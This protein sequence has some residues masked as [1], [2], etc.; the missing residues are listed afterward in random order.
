MKR[1]FLFLT[2]LML[3]NA[4]SAKLNVYAYAIDSIL[5][6]DTSIEVTD[7]HQSFITGKMQAEVLL[8]AYSDQS[9]HLTVTIQRSD[10]T[11]TDEF[12][13]GS[14]CRPSN[15]E[16]TQVIDYDVTTMQ[17]REIQIDYNPIAEGMETI[18]YTISDGV[19]P[20]IKVSV[21]F[22]YQATALEQMEVHPTVKGIYTIL[23]Q[24][25]VA[26]SIDEL[27]K[28]IYIVNGKKVVKQ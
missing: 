5:T 7:F 23:G 3:A 9:T 1:V 2:S 8:R 17:E 15:R 14:L 11:Y 28:G 4:V 18:A 10:T 24:R 13:A 6:E 16:Y 19:N 25:V 21:D 26:T 12:C 27:P 20:E 22:V